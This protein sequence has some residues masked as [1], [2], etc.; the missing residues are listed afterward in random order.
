[1][2]S[3]GISG[4]WELVVGLEWFCPRV[5]E[6]SPPVYAGVLLVEEDVGDL[7]RWFWIDLEIRGSLAAFMAASFTLD[8][9]CPIAV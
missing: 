6:Y 4:I 7:V 8:A 5:G 1:M 9:A 3:G 2:R